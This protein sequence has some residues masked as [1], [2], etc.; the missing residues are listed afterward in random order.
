MSQAVAIAEPERILRN[1][2]KPADIPEQ[3]KLPTPLVRAACGL[4]VQDECTV[5]EIAE[6]LKC[7]RDYLYRAFQKPHVI[8]YLARERRRYL[9]GDATLNRASRRLV[10]LLDSESDKIKLEVADRLLTAGGALPAERGKGSGTSV[11]V[12]VQVGYVIDL[13]EPAKPLIPL[14]E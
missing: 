7:R 4:Y 8:S 6:R 11:N 2:R 9:L 1:T 12:A 14:N 10:S 3:E 5:T 13:T